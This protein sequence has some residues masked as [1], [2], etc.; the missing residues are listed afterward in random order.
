VRAATPKEAAAVLG[1]EGGKNLGKLR[2]QD[3]EDWKKRVNAFAKTEAPISRNH[4]GGA[5]RS[6]VP[7]HRL[8]QIQRGVRA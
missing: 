3:A 1:A 8:R 2:R 7:L 4:R 6:P 5:G